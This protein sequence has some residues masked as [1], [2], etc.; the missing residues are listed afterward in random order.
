MAGLTRRVCGLTRRAGWLLLA[1][2]LATG[3]WSLSGLWTSATAAEPV[4]LPEPVRQRCLQLLRTSLASDDFW[5]AM[6]AAEG[7]TVG[8]YGE[9]VVEPLRRRLEQVSDAQQ[10]CGLARE[11]VRA[12]RLEFVSLMLETLADDDPY[13]HT[14]AAESL[15]KVTRIGDGR[16]LRQ[17]FETADD[18]KLK[19]MSA[20][21]LGNCGNPTAM[22]FLRQSL[23][24]DDPQRVM[25]A[26]WALGAIGDRQDIAPLRQ[27]RERIREPLP[28]AYIDHALALRGD[29]AGLAAL[30]ANLS[31]SDAAVRTYAANFAGD[32]GAAELV[33]PLTAMLDDAHADAAIRAAQSLLTF[34][35]P[36]AADRHDDRSQL[37]FSPTPDHPRWTEGSIVEL[38]DGRLLFAISRFQQR[39]SDFAQA[40]IVA[41]ESTDGGRSWGPPYVLQE[42]TGQMNVMSITLRRL[43]PTGRIGLFYLQKDSPQQLNLYVRFSDDDAQSFGTP[44]LISQSPGYHVCNND[45][46]LQLSSGRILI[47]VATTPDA[48]T[49]NHY[50]SHCLISDDGGASWR[51]S[52]GSVDADRR[53][54]MEPEVVELSDGRV[55]MLVRTQLGY[56][57]KSYSSDGGDSWSTLERLS[58]LPSPEAPC[59]VRRIPAT[60]QLLLIWND[61]YEP[62]AGHGG[63]RTPLSA[64]ISDDDGLTWRRLPPLEDDSQRTFSYTS[65]IF[66]G[67]R[68][69][70]SYWDSPSTTQYGNRF[71]SIPIAQ[72]TTLD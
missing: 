22:A 62:G 36:A 69:I 26:A 71:R 49:V 52:T 54:A 45:R 55:M 17:R 53:G 58:D 6:H 7:L 70:L 15:F 35:R 66:V 14:H 23:T 34:A 43:E 25:I 31:S 42:N 65:L 56:I 2:A 40:D 64:A 10:R 32:T 39:S 61:R 46:V 33:P 38:N 8:G 68:A 30:T 5:P 41:R 3:G 1:A 19:L 9:E 47:P 20:A 51:P 12:G 24:E 72:L 60:G 28:Q 13:G 11:L 48:V 44:H 29:A 50:T 63:P 57:G 18:D 59:T 21:A 16:W 27:A 37:V 67:D 4:E